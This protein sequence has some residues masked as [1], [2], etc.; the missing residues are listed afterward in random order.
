MRE[1]AQPGADIGELEERLL[2]IA[3]KHA[4]GTHPTDRADLRTEP[5]ALKNCIAEIQK[6]AGRTLTPDEINDILEELDARIQRL[7]RSTVSETE[8]AMLKPPLSSPR[9]C[10]KAQSSP[11]ETPL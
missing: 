4:A 6:A 9:T 8:E 3:K 11:R 1:M 10:G 5:M 7:K 2:D